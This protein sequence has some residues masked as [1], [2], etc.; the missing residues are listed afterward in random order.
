MT[1]SLVLAPCPALRAGLR[2]DR[3]KR[4]SDGLGQAWELRSRLAPG[5]PLP[6]S[7][8]AV[9]TPPPPPPRLKP[10]PCAPS[11]TPQASYNSGVSVVR[12]ADAPGALDR[13]PAAPVDGGPL[14]GPFSTPIVLISQPDR[15]SAYLLAD[16]RASFPL[17]REAQDRAVTSGKIEMTGFPARSDVRTQATHPRA[18]TRPAD[19]HTSP[20]AARPEPHA[21]ARRRVPPTLSPAARMARLVLG[22]LPPRPARRQTR[23]LHRRRL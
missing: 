6:R 9:A 20:G 12:R 3:S 16:T 2:G 14:G 18:A 23:R 10:A 17:H 8:R 5:A 19:P 7:H 13:Q 4:D 22:A 11:P 1:H 15:W 21:A